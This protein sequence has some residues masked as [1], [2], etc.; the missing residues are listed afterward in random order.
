MP[1]VYW[2]AMTAFALALVAA[3]VTEA[4]AFAETTF[5]AHS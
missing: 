1:Y 2:K 3:L 4:S 5:S